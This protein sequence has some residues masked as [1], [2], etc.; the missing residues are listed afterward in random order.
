MNSSPSVWGDGDEKGSLACDALS[1]KETLMDFV[2][3]FGPKHEFGPKRVGRRG[4]ERI[5]R[6]R[7]V[8]KE[9]IHIS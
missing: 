1:P 5:P 7:P 6:P 8:F 3:E 2:Y 9:D 4:R